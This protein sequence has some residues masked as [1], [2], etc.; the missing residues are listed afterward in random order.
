MIITFGIP[1][2]TEDRMNLTKAIDT[3]S[4]C[5]NLQ[6]RLRHMDE[7]NYAVGDGDTYPQFFELEDYRIDLIAILNQIRFIAKSSDIKASIKP[8]IGKFYL[9][10]E[11]AQAELF[12]GWGE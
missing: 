1:L 3:L 4:R 9:A 12:I 2:N 10:E 11:D 6:G 7:V 8:T 5:E